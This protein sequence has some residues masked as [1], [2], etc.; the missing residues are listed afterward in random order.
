MAK[1]DPSFSI[2]D[3]TGYWLRKTYNMVSINLQKR[4]DD[5]G[6]T[7]AQWPILYGL[8]Q[9][10]CESPAELAEYLGLYRSAIT[11]LLDRLE[12]KGLVTRENSPSDRR[13]LKIVLTEKGRN[14]VPKLAEISR[15]TNNQVLA[16]LT[17]TE[18]AE[19]DRIL[20]KIA[21]NAANSLD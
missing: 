21:L 4:F 6:V 15:E 11:R 9:G 7:V 5:H 19:V 1:L 10:I 14:L 16:G 12:K 13:S 2:T 20:K 3:S 8:H 17:C 18:I